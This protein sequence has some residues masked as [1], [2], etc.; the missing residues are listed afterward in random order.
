MKISLSLLF[1]FF[2]NSVPFLGKNTKCFFHDIFEDK[3][4]VGSKVNSCHISSLFL[5][6]TVSHCTGS[7]IFQGSQNM[8][9]L[10]MVSVKCPSLKSPQIFYQM[11]SLLRASV[12][13][14][15]SITDGV[16]RNEN[17]AEIIP[18]FSTFSNF[19]KKKKKICI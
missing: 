19:F 14:N 12:Y 8:I 17:F 6:K 5:S 7:N 3:C 2:F 4:S 9:R 16:H 15:P 11:Y 10:D 13:K 18:V 1:V